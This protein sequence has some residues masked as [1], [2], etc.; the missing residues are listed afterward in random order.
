MISA[1]PVY[2][3]DGLEVIMGV[4]EK[5]G[6][7]YGRGFHLRKCD[8][9]EDIGDGWNNLVSTLRGDYERA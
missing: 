6:K 7:R 1:I 2:G 8:T 3:A 9:A 4:F 5:N